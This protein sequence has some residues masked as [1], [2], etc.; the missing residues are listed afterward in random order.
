MIVRSA[1]CGPL[2]ANCYVLAAGQGRDA[3]IIDPG[4]DAFDT[5]AELLGEIEGTPVAILATHGH[6]DHVG[7]AGRVGNH[8]GIPTYIHSLDKPWLFDPALGLD[9]GFAAWIFRMFPGSFP[10]PERI[11][12]LDGLN[13]LDVAGLS[14]TVI[15]APG[16]SGGCVL[17]RVED[18]ESGTFV[19]TGDVL[20][21]GAI[22]RTDLPSGDSAA[23]KRSLT[24]AVLTLPDSAKI[25][26]GHG[27]A[28]TMARERAT[29]PYLTP[30][31]LAG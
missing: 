18:P 4:M 29:N 6:I 1:P 27:P 12:T 9:P 11:E 22:G 5:V 3:V 10:P 24:Q 17:Y 8:Y 25:F 31:F 15:H 26:P 28:S 7:D 30:R 2:E 21:A 14:I 23:M 13:T 16:H 20:F 19:F